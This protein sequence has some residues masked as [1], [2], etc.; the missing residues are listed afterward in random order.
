MCL[1]L[2]AILSCTM[3]NTQ[4]TPCFVW[5]MSQIVSISNCCWGFNRPALWDG[6]ELTVLFQLGFNCLSF[7][8]FTRFD[9][10]SHS[11]HAIFL[12]TTCWQSKWSAASP[13]S[14][15]WRVMSECDAI[16]CNR[17][18]I[19][20]WNDTIL[21]QR[22]CI[23]K[24][25]WSFFDRLWQLWIIWF[26]HI[27]IKN[28]M[29]VI[30]DDSET[31]LFTGHAVDMCN[32]EHFHNTFRIVNV[33]FHVF[34]FTHRLWKLQKLQTLNSVSS[35]G[36]T[37]LDY[38]WTV[39]VFMLSVWTIFARP[40]FP[41]LDWSWF[42]A[43]LNKIPQQTAEW[44]WSL[45]VL[46]CVSANFGLRI[47]FGACLILGGQHD[48]CPEKLSSL[49]GVCWEVKVGKSLFCLW[50]SR[51]CEASR[52]IQLLRPVR[53]KEATGTRCEM[54]PKTGWLPSALAARFDAHRLR[55]H[56]L[57]LRSSNLILASNISGPEGAGDASRRSFLGWRTRHHGCWDRCW[58]LWQKSLGIR[59]PGHARWPHR[60]RDRR[61][62]RQAGNHEWFS[63]AGE[64]FLPAR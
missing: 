46:F 51:A 26:L 50:G 57:R 34:H 54:M 7:N 10:L 1:H 62:R 5:F 25:S 42:V 4:R 24:V 38:V 60:D 8:E 44:R 37:C 32:G 64:Y 28:W 63:T 27:I 31:K 58:S 45:R 55:A 40:S 56:L 21:F 59:L 15:Q 61:S 35:A 17:T 52:W 39:N 20:I 14:M 11:L 9:K 48:L 23:W 30:I 12:W 47:A 16:N 6:I 49:G 43:Q 3:G 33:T 29:P 53:W 19:N 13:M 36:K 18:F 2:V 22:F 41:F